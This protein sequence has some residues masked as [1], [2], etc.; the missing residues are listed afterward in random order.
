MTEKITG[1]ER[2]EVSIRAD[3]IVLPGF[4]TVPEQFRGT[5]I[6]AHGS[7]SGRFSPRNNFLA[8][9]LNRAGI[10]TLLLDLL[11]EEESESRRK[12]FDLQLLSER[13]IHAINWVAENVDG[14]GK[15]VGIFGA[16]TGAAAAILASVNSS[17]PVGAIVSRGGRVDLAFEYIEKLESPILLIVGSKDT[18]TMLGNEKIYSRLSCTKKMVVINNAT[19]LF[20][21]EGAL[22]QVAEHAREWFT[23]HLW[24][25]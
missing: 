24:V 15:S 2:R 13:I 20:E 16:S 21:E 1:E 18:E 10:A 3:N 22:D 8:E 5:V 12:V 4:L 14:D 19:H 25:R 7:G 17:I 9:T 23:Q 6:F 11:T